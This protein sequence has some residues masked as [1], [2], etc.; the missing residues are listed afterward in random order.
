MLEEYNPY[1]LTAY[2]DSGCSICF[3]KRSL[4]SEFMWQK[5]K[6]PLQV[7]IAGNSLMSHNEAIKGLNIEIGG[8]QCVILV[9]WATNQPLHDIIIGNN[10]Q[11]LYS[12]CT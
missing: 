8:V 11:R 3:G 10:F 5:A 7:S 6:N 9:L 2:I 12:P 4:F 1:K